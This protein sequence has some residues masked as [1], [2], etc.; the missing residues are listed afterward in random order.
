MHLDSRLISLAA[1]LKIHA[2]QYIK[3]GRQITDLGGLLYMAEDE[4]GDPGRPLS[5]DEA[6]ALK[7]HLIEMSKLCGQLGLKIAKRQMDRAVSDPPRSSREFDQ[8]VSVMEHELEE[9]LFLFVPADRAAFYER[10]ISFPSFPNA[11]K[12]LVR[13][14]NCFAASEDIACVFHCMRAVEIALR[15]V[16]SCLGLSLPA[17]SNRSWGNYCNAIRDEIVRRG[18]AW[19]RA[20]EFQEILT[21]LVNVKDGWRNSSLH[22]DASYSEEDAKRILA[23]VAFFI[24]KVSSRMDEQGLPLA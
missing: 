17:T 9:Q 20:G 12:E 24:E 1:M 23:A 16:Y 6:Q 18:K 21:T 15:A 5:A 14:G 22:V 19:A 2:D 10:P 13:A 7:A 3:L 8:A 4:P 11:T